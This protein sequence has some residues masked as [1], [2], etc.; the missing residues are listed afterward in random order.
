VYIT[1]IF[2]KCLASHSD[3]EQV[4]L[5]RGNR[6]KEYGR[7]AYASR[8]ASVIHVLLFLVWSEDTGGCDVDSHDTENTSG[9][10]SR[11][12]YHWFHQ[13]RQGGSTFRYQV[14]PISGS[15]SL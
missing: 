3:A 9:G 12:G 10:G 15:P 14:G 7:S 8:Y 5:F 13:K 11:F 2:L 4:T 1:D 6:H